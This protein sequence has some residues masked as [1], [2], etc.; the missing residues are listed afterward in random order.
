MSVVEVD[1]THHITTSE[2]FAASIPTLVGFM[3][4]QSLVIVML[5]KS[6]VVVTMR[7][8]LPQEWDSALADVQSTIFRIGADEVLVAVLTDRGEEALPFTSEV[9]GLMLSLNVHGVGTRDALLIENG[10]YWSYI[11]PS[12]SCCSAQGEFI[13]GWAFAD[14]TSESND[15][16]GVVA[17]FALKEDGQPS[18]AVVRQVV[19]ELSHDPLKRAV[20]AW[21]CLERLERDAD[22]SETGSAGDSLRAA[23]QLSM[24]DV[25][26]RD[27]VLGKIASSD[28][29]RS[30]AMA[31]ADVALRSSTEVQKLMCGAAAAA[32]MAT[33]DSTL[34]A[35]CL[36][37]HA[38]DDS[39]A[40][41][42]MGSIRSAFP[43]GEIAQVLRDSM[44]IVLKQLNVKESA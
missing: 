6:R 33:C 44:P 1:T 13:T 37:D 42:V 30:L 3:P 19:K 26:C 2:E 39:L 31:L 28:S 12:D 14:E 41:L 5:Q 20:H 15:R 4:L 10:R 24:L 36:A 7:I 43:P 40:V 9:S 29:G 34:P 27:F 16:A 11:C 35:S 23:I 17:K 8:D 18:A 21:Q 32:L 38:G 22:L 25:R